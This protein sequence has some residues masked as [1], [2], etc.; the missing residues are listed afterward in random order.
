MTPEV[1]DSVWYA[2][3]REVATDTTCCD[4]NR[5]KSRGTVF[6]VSSAAQVSR[7]TRTVS[8]MY[9][10]AQHS[11]RVYYA[12]SCDCFLYWHVLLRLLSYSTPLARIR[13]P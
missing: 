8:L 11:P 12:L 4:A 3:L 13:V 2:I 10:L 5:G 9:T 7:H 6:S 1:V